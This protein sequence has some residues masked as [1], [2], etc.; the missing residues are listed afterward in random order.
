MTCFFVLK[1]T[2]VL[3]RLY[4]SVYHLYSATSYFS[5]FLI[6]IKDAITRP[7]P[8]P[9]RI[10]AT[11][12]RA[13]VLRNMNPTPSPI[14]VVPPMTHVLLSSFLFIIIYP[15]FP[16]RYNNF[17]YITLISY[18]F[19]DIIKILHTE[20]LADMLQAIAGNG[21]AAIDK[22]GLN[23]QCMITLRLNLERLISLSK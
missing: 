21:D 14:S 7:T 2:C 13:D 10:E 1:S 22:W 15:F 3:N 12:I 17:K 20:Y 4:G 18:F 9:M 11:N 16:F 19:D 6:E 5:R 23:T 8:I